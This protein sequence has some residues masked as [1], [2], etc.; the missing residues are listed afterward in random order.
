[1][2]PYSSHVTV[3]DATIGI[4][5][6]LVQ[7]LI[8][9]IFALAAVYIGIRVFDR[10]TPDLDEM[11]E[12]KRGNVAIGILLA[13]VILSIATV[14]QR[15]VAVLSAPFFT[16]GLSLS[17]RLV[18]FAGGIIT[19]LLSLA[20]ALFVIRMAIYVFDKITKGIDEQAELRNGNI[21]IA[22]LLAG[23]LL[24]IATVIQGGTAS[25]TAAFA[26]LGE[27]LFG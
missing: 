4:V 10:F 9:L 25:L 23:I 17:G 27:A 13:A 3:T 6:A 14:I 21:A 2:I 1:M 11:A 8:A 15:G 22:I 26:T 19:L 5:L 7:V 16:P 12:L 20:L 18:A 24:A